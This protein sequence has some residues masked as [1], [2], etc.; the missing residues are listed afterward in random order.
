MSNEHE[1]NNYVLTMNGHVIRVYLDLSKSHTDPANMRAIKKNKDGTY[2]I[3]WTQKVTDDKGNT[4][5]CE[6][7]DTIIDEGANIKS[8]I[9]KGKALGIY[10]SSKQRKEDIL[11][12]MAEYWE[13]MAKE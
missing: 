12:F 4:Y 2:Q 9:A 7:N 11:N 5:E 1:F 13:T 3:A 10:R 6:F 8:M